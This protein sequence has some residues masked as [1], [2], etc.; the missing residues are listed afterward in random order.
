MRKQHNMIK[1]NFNKRAFVYGVLASVACLTFA[2]ITGGI[3][4]AFVGLL[5]LVFHLICL[6]SK[7]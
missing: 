1:K 6:I 3:F 5:S 2:A 4:F 7:S